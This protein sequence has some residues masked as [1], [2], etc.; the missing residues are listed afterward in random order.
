MIVLLKQRITIVRNIKKWCKH[1]QTV[2]GMT[3]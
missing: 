2:Y 1:S 3:A